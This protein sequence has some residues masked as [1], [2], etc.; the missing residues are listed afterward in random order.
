MSFEQRDFSEGFFLDPGTISAVHRVQ[1]G[2]PLTLFVGAGVSADQGIPQWSSLVRQTLEEVL[3][4]ASNK[5]A[6]RW[7]DLRGKETDF[8]DKVLNASFQLPVA[9]MIDQLCEEVAP[10]KTPWPTFRNDLLRNAIYRDNGKFRRFDT[11][12]SLARSILTLAI[13]V[14]VLAPENDLHIVSTNY[15]DIFR[16]IIKSDAE[17][18]SQLDAVGLRFKVYAEDAPAASSRT[19][20]PIVHIHGFIP[21]RGNSI[22]PIFSEPDY[23]WWTHQGPFRD[24]VQARFD[25]GCMLMVG[26]SMRDYNIVTYVKRTRY[27][28]DKVTRYAM[29]P[30]QGDAGYKVAGREQRDSYSNLMSGRLSNL[31]IRMLSPDFYGQVNQFLFETTLYTICKFENRPYVDYMSR[32][33]AWWST[34][35]Q[36]KYGDDTVR[37]N[38]TK[39]LQAKA[40]ELHAD[41]IH[42]ADHLKL[43]VWLRPEITADSDPRYFELWANSQSMWLS[44]TAYRPHRVRTSVESA[45]PAVRTFGSRSAQWGEDATRTDRRWTHFVA[46]PVILYDAPHETIPVGAVVLRICAPDSVGLPAT[47]LTDRHRH[48]ISSALIALGTEVLSPA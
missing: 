21:R 4:L 40:M 7:R 16:E 31:G 2:D 39:Q 11:N 38:L 27:D 18:R 12:P 5:R 44:G 10:K 13:A 23:I 33:G 37:G 19:E 42:D 29:L 3:K 17:I 34:F 22:R 6:S 35:S 8:A 46:V 15:D 14:K 24:Y 28:T 41:Y 20:I 36:S 30:V 45:E 43:E 47:K 48:A 26:T 32:L 9:T 25:K 1:Q